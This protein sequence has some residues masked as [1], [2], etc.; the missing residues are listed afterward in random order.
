[1]KITIASFSY[2][3]GRKENEDSMCTVSAN[4]F[5]LC[6]VADGLGG[7]QAGAVA[8]KMV[9]D[10]I[11]KQSNELQE[12]TAESIRTMF[13][14]ANATVYQNQPSVGSMKSTL[15]ALWY[16]NHQTIVAHSG[17]TRIYGFENGEI[18]YQSTDHSVS[19][20]AVLTGEIQKEEIRFHIDRNKVLSVLGGEE[21]P[22]VELKE[23]PYGEQEQTYLLCSDGFWEYVWEDEMC[24][25]LAKAKHPQDFLD[26][27]LARL[28]KRVEEGHDNFTA[29]CIQMKEE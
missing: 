8:S 19:Q 25:D 15:A 9:I 26:S 5:A 4:E 16:Y 3:G 7:H 29:V 27:M 18:F 22:R 2:R 13:H 17:D 10:S 12:I 1:M 28:A 11:Q 21:P 24:I 23:L 14:N 6:A 20:L